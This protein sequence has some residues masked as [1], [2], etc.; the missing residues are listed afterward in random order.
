MTMAEHFC[1]MFDSKF[2]SIGLALHE[3][4]RTQAPDC[5]LWV[6]C[7]D[8]ATA[9]AL[10][11]IAAPGLRPIAL[12]DVETETLRAVRATRTNREYYW[13]LT[14]WMFDLVFDRAPDALRVT[15]VDADVYFFQPPARLLDRMGD[16]RDVLITHHAFAPQYDY[17][18]ISG[19]YCV[20]FIA[21][22]RTPAARGAI[23][24]WRD[25][26]L[27]WCY[28]RVERDR[29]GDQRYLEQWPAMLADRLLIVNSAEETGAPWNACLAEQRPGPWTPV[30]YHF[31]G[32]RCLTG[33][34]ALLKPPTPD[35]EIGP[36]A[37]RLYRTYVLAIKRVRRL[38]RRARIAIADVE[39]PQG[40]EDYDPWPIV[41]RRIARLVK[42]RLQP[43][44]RKPIISVR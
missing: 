21:V 35:Y 4:L 23:A 12:G 14:P 7:L 38:L 29:F 41:F 24:W 5:V 10:T 26:C 2:L 9:D 22:R 37:W 6:L 3:S 19:P 17:T 1:T 36:N 40:Y 31:H 8:S 27:E 30:F 11:T 18:A 42:R 15:Y 20:Q 43:L 33:G 44:E 34:R 13:T 39:A 25:R 16:D 32:F 28:A